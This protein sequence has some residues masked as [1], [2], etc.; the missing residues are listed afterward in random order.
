MGSLGFPGRELC[1]PTGNLHDLGIQLI[2]D[3][4][5]ELRVWMEAPPAPIPALQDSLGM[6]FPGS[7]HRS[8]DLLSLWRVRMESREWD[9]GVF[10][11]T[12]AM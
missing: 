5:W 10:W 7:R 6:V 12:G 1:V 8:R 2:P 9:M 4:L 3:S 11:D